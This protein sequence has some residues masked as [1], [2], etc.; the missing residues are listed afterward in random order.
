MITKTKSQPSSEKMG[1]KRAGTPALLNLKKKIQ[2]QE[3]PSASETT[4]VAHW[5]VNEALDV[6]SKVFKNRK[7]DSKQ[8][9]EHEVE[10]LFKA[11]NKIFLQIQLKKIP[12]NMSTFIHSLELPHH[13]RHDLSDGYDTCLIVKDLNKPSLPDREEDLEASRE[14]VKKFLKAASAENLITDVLPMRQLKF[15]FQTPAQKKK[16]SKEYE[17][18]VCDKRLLMN[19]YSKLSLTLGKQFWIDSKK[20]P[21]T[22][23]VKADNLKELLEAKLNQTHLYMS[24][25]GSTL[26]MTVG[27][28]EQDRQKVL[29][30]LMAVLG[31]IKKIFG[32]N[33]SVLGLKTALSMEVMFYVDLASSNDISPITLPKKESGEQFIEDDF[34]MLTGKSKVRVY[35]DGT[36][37]IRTGFK[38]AENVAADED[39]KEEEPDENE[40]KLIRYVNNPRDKDQ[41]KR[42]KAGQLSFKRKR[43]HKLAGKN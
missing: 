2:R 33:I 28:I 8:N 10:P 11:N 9:D 39:D 6:L 13:W 22:V 7:T 29:A 40:R 4:Y 30:N 18:F 16:L 12:Y 24:G 31:W 20:V 37:K 43:G 32:D 1:K 27:L 41:W 36:I 3:E 23:D 19:K 38:D 17:A 42:H 21:V 5:K 15:E 26:S 34:D 25:K 14:H 35:R